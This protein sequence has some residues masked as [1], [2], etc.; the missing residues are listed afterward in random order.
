MKAEG[1]DIRKSFY[2][3]S[4][5]DYDTSGWIIRDAFLNDLRFFR[6]KHIKHMDLILPG[7]FS[8]EEIELNKFP[9]RTP[10][11]MEAKNKKWL[12]ESGGID[13]E[14]YGLEADAAPAERIQELFTSATQYLVKSTEPIRR[15]RALL[16]LSDALDEY[17]MAR[18]QVEET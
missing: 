7:I 13:G 1:I 10:P 11:E 6:V 17:I 3:F 14:L 12:R 18:L 16:L 5:V 2:T 8:Q 15:A 4:L 9:L